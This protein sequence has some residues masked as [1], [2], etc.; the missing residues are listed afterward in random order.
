MGA[1]GAWGGGGVTGRH[2][3]LWR[4]TFRTSE[5]GANP[6][7]NVSDP[8]PPKLRPQPVHTIPPH[9]YL[10]GSYSLPLILPLHTVHTYSTYIHTTYIH[11]YIG[12]SIYLSIYLSPPSHRKLSRPPGQCGPFPNSVQQRQTPKGEEKK[13]KKKKKGARSRF[14]ATG[15]G[16][17]QYVSVPRSR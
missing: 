6:T 8:P 10:R 4:E 7:D 3:R 14:R 12:I 5:G 13:K 17:T 9:A 16:R 11:T 15:P 1:R 2:S